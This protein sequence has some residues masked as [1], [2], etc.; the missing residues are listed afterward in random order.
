MKGSKGAVVQSQLRISSM[1]LY[2]P[3]SEALRIVHGACNKLHMRTTH[4][5]LRHFESFLW[6]KSDL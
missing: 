5:L 4:I 1:V 2:Q 6:I 3:R